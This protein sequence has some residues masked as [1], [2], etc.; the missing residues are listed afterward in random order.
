MHLLLIIFI[1]VLSIPANEVAEPSAFFLCSCLR[2]V[3]YQD[4]LRQ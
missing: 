3:G 2:R 4:Q 1:V